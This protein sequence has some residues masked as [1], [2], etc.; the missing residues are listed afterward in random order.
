MLGAKFRES[1]LGAGLLAAL[2]A[3]VL[4]PTAAAAGPTDWTKLRALNIT[5]QGGEDE[6]PSNTMYALERSM[7]L[8]ADMLELDIHTS[9]DGDLMVIHDGT[10]DRTTNGSGSVYEMTTRE[11][12]A[13]DAGYN[14]VPGEGIERDLPAA[15]Y[16][17]R[18]VR[19]GDRK[20]PPS[21]RP[22]DFRIPTLEEVIDAYPKV[23]INIEIKGAADDDLDSF[24]RNADALAAYLNK[25]GRSRGIMVASFNDEA[26]ARFHKAAPQIDLAPAIGGVAGY[27]LNGTLPPAG[28]KAFQVPLGFNGIT[29]TDQAFI[30]RAHS[31]DYGVHVWTINDEPTMK[32]LL[33]WGADGIMTAEPARLEKVLCRSDADRPDRP[34][35][36]PGQH[37]NRRVSIAC[38]IE[39]TTIE[40]NRSGRR[41]EITLERH[42]DFDSRC[43]GRVALRGLG[44]TARRKGSFSF[45]WT[46]PSEGGPSER[47]ATIRLSGRLRHA[48]RR[49]GTGRVLVH[50]YSAFVEKSQLEVG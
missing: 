10:V 28:S 14:I 29:V 27:V 24:F 12:Q 1:I 17:Y 15:S 49:R 7:R 47:T 36:F 22:D 40:L 45:G 38:D 3:L 30:D 32:R 6:A 39:A 16:P 9:S 50:P 5:H 35:S 43:A 33:G 11:I 46:R 44:T 37:C 42:D 19:V 2:T 34:A 41:A 21:F 13:L 20:P 26:L 25:L 23:P 48:L 18:G 8:G 4:L 31:D